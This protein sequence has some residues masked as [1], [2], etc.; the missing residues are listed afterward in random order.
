MKN[1]SGNGC[2]VR[3]VEVSAPASNF[4]DSV[5][6]RAL[7]SN[8]KSLKVL[9]IFLSELNNQLIQALPILNIFI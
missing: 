1:A 7:T 3:N 8:K 5:D 2:M 6:K 9:G 4:M